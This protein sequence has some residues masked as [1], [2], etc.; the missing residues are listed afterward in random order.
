MGFFADVI[1][2]IIERV[3]KMLR[4]NNAQESQ[5]RLEDVTLYPNR[6]EL[7][8]GNVDPD[9][10]P[11]RASRFISEQKRLTEYLHYHFLIIKDVNKREEYKNRVKSLCN[12]LDS[13]EKE[14][15]QI[16]EQGG[17]TSLYSSV[18]GKH[19]RVSRELNAVIDEVN[20]VID[21]C[22]WKKE[23]DNRFSFSNKSY[24]SAFSGVFNDKDFEII[25]NQIEIQKNLSEIAETHYCY[26]SGYGVF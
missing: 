21:Y 3:R 24:Y 18:A 13:I 19:Q 14:F 17:L 9:S 2:E 1:N 23:K 10:L 12:E 25:N 8:S 15:F 7:F 4:M 6:S 5:L 26:G 20:A 11:K 22:P 16:Q